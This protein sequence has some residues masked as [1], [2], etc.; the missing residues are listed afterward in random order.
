VTRLPFFNSATA[1][2][3]SRAP[4]VPRAGRNVPLMITLI[5]FVPE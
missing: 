2:P 4:V 5:T 1:V 3:P